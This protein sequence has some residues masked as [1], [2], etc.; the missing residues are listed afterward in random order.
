MKRELR[1][2]RER[3]DEE[4]AERGLEEGR[5]RL[6][7]L[8]TRCRAA[9]ET[10]PANPNPADPSLLRIGDR[11]R[12]VSLGQDGVVIGL[13]DDRG[14]ALVLAGRIKVSVRADGLARLQGVKE[15]KMPGTGGAAALYA[16]KLDSISP[17][18]SVRGENL[19]DA[20]AAAAKYLDDAFIA[21]LREV[22]IIHGRGEGI[23][24]EGIR[25]MLKKNKQVKG[26]RAGAYNEGGDGVTICTMM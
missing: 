4:A 6:K 12:V 25:G 3:G 22:T 15:K 5:R 16:G 19:D 11:V 9:A 26:F 7:T 1:E 13:P 14:E 2:F 8:E 20:L 18:L 21:G 24:R 17:S 10:P 23:L